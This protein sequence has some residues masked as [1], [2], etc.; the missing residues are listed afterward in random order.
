[1]KAVL[2]YLIESM[3]AS[4]LVWLGY[5]L[6][7]ERLTF[8]SWN[9]A[10][11]LLGMLLAFSL[12]LLSIP[13]SWARP[14][15]V[16]AILPFADFGQN[17]E[18]STQ[19]SSALLDWSAGGLLLSCWLGIAL[20]LIARLAIGVLILWRKIR[21]A[22]R[23]PKGGLTLAFHTSFSPSSFFGYVLL[24]Q[25]G[26]SGEALEQILAHESS[27]IRHWHSLDLL[28]LQ[29]VKALFWF[30]PFLYLLERA[31][32]EVHEFQADAEVVKTFE[33][34][35]YSR[36]LVQSLWASQGDF[37]PSFNQFQTKKR[38]VMMNKTKS[39]A[40]ERLRFLMGIP[41]VVAMLGLF[42]CQMGSSD[43]DLVGTWTGTD[44]EFEQTQ[45]P[46]LPGVVEGGKNL[47]VDG[48][49]VLNAD[50]TYEIR[51]SSRTINGKGV[52][53]LDG[54]VLRTTDDKGNV[55]EYEVVSSSATK[56]VTKHHV[57]LETP[58]GVLEGTIVLSYEK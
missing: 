32:K 29:I 18:S 11:L 25:D 12:P 58:M 41:L 2:E 17:Q 19:A 55:I 37:I 52:W 21:Q 22:E 31:L 10:Y 28:V 51:D 40:K 56:L 42:S 54:S 3:L 47:H 35:P 7:L 5:R 20:L 46:D 26:L 4:G 43:E 44:F 53:E 45:G 38:I 27:H 36:L 9:R 34:I 13:L 50:K 8:F 48:K 33:A 57:S 16:P 39:N 6:F 23:V 30:N 15:V 1:M 14:T 24:P 49:M